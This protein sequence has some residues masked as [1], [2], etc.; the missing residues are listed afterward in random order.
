MSA[1]KRRFFLL[2]AAFAATLPAT[3]LAE[4][5]VERVRFA[6]G[7]SSAEV[8]GQIR[9]YD[10]VDYLI[11]ARAGQHLHVTLTV[12]RGHAIMVVRAPGSD[13][14]LF[15]GSTSSEKRFETIL[16]AS[17]DYRIRVFMMRAFARRNERSAY[18]LKVEIR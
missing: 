12:L 17:G 15:D 9:G 1:M 8:R 16:S 3:A 5:R 2:A 6:R 7:T 14:N 4:N 10:Y 18:R 11:G 13:E